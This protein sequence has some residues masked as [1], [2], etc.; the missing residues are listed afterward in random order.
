MPAC[1]PAKLHAVETTMEQAISDVK[2]R[3]SGTVTPPL[4]PST[5]SAT[6]LDWLNFFLAD[7]QTGVGPFLATYLAANHWNAQ[8]VGIA[9]TVG[10]IAGIVFQTPAGALVD[11][12]KSRRAVIAVAVSGVAAGA[13][14]IALLPTFSGIMLAQVLIG[15]LSSVFIPATCAISIGIVGHALFDE[16]Q[17]RN[18]AFNSA[19]NVFTALLIGAVGYFISNRASFLLVALLA[20]PTMLALRAIR[21]GEIDDARARGGTDANSNASV[22]DLL[23]DRP[24]LTFFA[25]AVLFHFAN[26]AMLPLLGETLAKGKDDTAMLFMSACVITTQFVVIFISRAA[27]KA[28]ASIGRKRLLLIG[29][30]VLPIR[31]VLYTLTDDAVWLVAIQILDGIAVGIFN[32]VSV[33]VIADLTQGSGRFNLSLGASTTAIGIGASLSQAI[34]GAISH[35]LGSNAGFLFLA[36]VALFALGILFFMMPETRDMSFSNRSPSRERF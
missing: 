18:Q 30:S 22:A 16:R 21:P 19:G 11:R 26:A 34:A 15:G 23:K 6:G 5:A 17:G 27:G 14:I 20:I 3:E 28:A 33:L 35:H 4:Q 32:V 10:G 8:Q 12:V 31:G 13:I 24:L 1:A 29:F 7:V 36:A 25:C 2:T 9:L